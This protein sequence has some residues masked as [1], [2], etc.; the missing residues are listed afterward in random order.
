MRYDNFIIGFGNVGQRVAAV[1]V[2]K[3]ES[4]GALVRAGRKHD[5][6]DLIEGDLDKPETLGNLPLKNTRLY[7]FAPPP[8]AGLSD[9]RMHNFL[10]SLSVENFP[11]RILYISTTGVY[12]DAAGEWID[13]N[14]PLNPQN[15]RAR[16]RVDAEQ[17]LAAW[18]AANAVEFVILRVVGIYDPQ[19]LPIERLQAGM[20]V[21]REED[22]GPSN[23]IH[24]D[25]LTRICVTAMEQAP[26]GAIYNVSDGHPSSMTDFYMRVADLAGLPAPE[27]VTW[28]EAERVFSPMMLEFLRESKKVSNAKLLHDL[29]INLQYP[30]L[31]EGLAAR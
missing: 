31:D 10:A 19:H 9:P 13:E 14:T 20:K 12:G 7:Y 6:V 23:R 22:A 2:E 3:D 11:K 4:V 21:L 30:S 1:C 18:C 26:A 8:N 25:D 15:D 16:R 17:Q 24:V 27:A 28:E 5:T 29:R